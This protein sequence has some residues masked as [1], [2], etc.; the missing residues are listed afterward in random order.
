MYLAI[1][2]QSLTMGTYK[3]SLGQLES[4]ITTSHLSITFLQT[5]QA[6]KH[7]QAFSL[8]TSVITFS[9]SHFQ[10]IRNSISHQPRTQLGTSAQQILTTSS[11]HLGQQHGKTLSAL[12]TQMTATMH[13]G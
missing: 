1:M 13:F 11:K 5:V 7:K 9:H 3:Q 4:T 10:T 12:M 6:P 8:A 2:T